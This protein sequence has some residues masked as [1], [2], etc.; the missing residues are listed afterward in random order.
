LVQ[1]SPVPG[2]PAFKLACGR[3]PD[4]GR[5]LCSQPTLSRLEN[6]PALRDVMR[7][8]YALVDQWMASYATAPPSVR[9]D[10]DDTCDVVHGHQQLSLFNAHYD[11]PRMNEGTSPRINDERKLRQPSSKGV[12]AM[13]DDEQKIADAVARAF[14]TLS[15][16]LSRELS[17]AFNQIAQQI[18]RVQKQQLEIVDLVGS[19][20]E[21]ISA[22][23]KIRDGDVERHNEYARAIEQLSQAQMK[24]AQFID[25]LATQYG[26]LFKALSNRLD[27]IEKEAFG[28]NYNQEPSTPPLN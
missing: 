27:A 1:N 2:H 5:D 7:L 19:Q 8:T 13:T 16:S 14:E 15:E 10:I 25:V 17:D 21:A 24:I 6:A 26:Q 23:E 28:P 4:T 9:L 11:V 22:R 12:E 20:A 3:L 18:G